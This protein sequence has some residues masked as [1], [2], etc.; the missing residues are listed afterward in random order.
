MKFLYDIMQKTSGNNGNYRNV[1]PILTRGNQMKL[2]AAKRDHPE[3]PKPK[4]EFLTPG[5]NA[6]TDNEMKALWY[7]DRVVKVTDRL[8]DYIQ[9]IDD[10]V[11]RAA[12]EHRD[13]F[14]PPT[15]PPLP[16]PPTEPPLR[17]SQA[18]EAARQTQEMAQYLANMAKKAVDDAKVHMNETAHNISEV[19]A[20][21]V[22]KAIEV[23]MGH[24]LTTLPPTEPPTVPP[25]FVIEAK[26]PPAP[27][28]GGAP[29]GPGGAPGAPGSPGGLPPAP[30]PAPGDVPAVEGPAAAEGEPASLLSYLSRRVQKH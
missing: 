6:R 15:P 25:Q 27:G 8:R 14:V 29:G 23:E 10:R 4:A 11:Q 17:G 7:S 1:K 12:R 20:D 5:P 3:A 16:N 2:L 21:K 9:D 19:V 22:A 28:A 13:K 18:L 26:T 30:A 24:L